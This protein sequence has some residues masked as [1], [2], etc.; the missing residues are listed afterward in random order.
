MPHGRH[1]LSHSLFSERRPVMKTTVNGIEITSKMAAVLQDWYDDGR[2][3][4]M[5]PCVYV[6]WLCG[7]QDYL[8]RIWVDRN[9]DAEDIPELKDCIHGLIQIKDDLKKFIPEKKE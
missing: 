1:G 6:E 7:V 4:D 3:E 5:K 9:D 8:T 2:I